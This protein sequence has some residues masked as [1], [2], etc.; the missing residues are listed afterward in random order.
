[1]GEDTDGSSWERPVWD[2][3]LEQAKSLYHKAK[4]GNFDLVLGVLVSANPPE[5]EVLVRHANATSGW[6]LLHQA[7]YHGNVEACRALL[8]YGADRTVRSRPDYTSGDGKI[9]HETAAEVALRYRE[10]CLGSAP[11]S[12]LDGQRYLEC[13]QALGEVIEVAPEPEDTPSKLSRKSVS[14]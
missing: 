8:E 4:C 14:V 7:C 11:G 9:H 13:A 3:Q 12:I 5:R 2:E 1:M 6:T 10:R